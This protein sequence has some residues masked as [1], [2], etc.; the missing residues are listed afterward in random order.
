L[1]KARSRMV[2][3]SV[4]LATACDS[5]TAPPAAICHIS[6]VVPL[7]LQV[8][9]YRAI[10]PMPSE[11]C[12]LFPANASP[13]TAEYLLV[14]QAT[15][16]T[17]DLTST[18]KLTGGT[19]AM[20]AP[21]VVAALQSAPL[22]PPQR[23]H[24]MLREMERT[25]AYPGVTAAAAARPQL[26]APPAAIPPPNVGD[27]G[28]FKV[29][30]SITNLRYDSV[31]AF[32]Q[33]VGAHIAIYVD[34][35][36]PPGLTISGLDSLRDAFDQKLY[37]ADT[38]AFG[39]ESDIDGNGIVIVLMT[40][41]VNKMVTAAECQST[42]YVAGFFYGADI[43]LAVN[44]SFNHGEIFY[45]IVADPGA[46]L[47]CGHSVNA[48]KQVVAGTLVHEF[49]HMISYNQH[50]RIRHT[51][52]EVLWLNE[53]LSH[54]A[55]ELGGRTFLPDMTTFCYYV[56][57]DLYNAGQYL[58]APGTYPLVDTAGIGGLANRGAGWLFVRY[59]VDRFGQDTTLAGNN[60]IT[61]ALDNTSA[62]GTIN[63]AQ[64]TGVPFATT[65]QEWALANWV[66]DLPGF[67][68]PTALKYE[69]WA[70]RSA[71]PTLRATCGSP[72]PPTFPLVA[73]A[74]AGPNINLSGTMASG[75]GAVYQRALQGPGAPAFTLLFSDATGAQLK[76]TV[77][78]RLNVIRIR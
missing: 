48:V 23:F 15:T 10:D 60:A 44:L 65:A 20:A 6:A 26:V 2:F 61:R 74:D 17:P 32:A 67:T 40:N 21:S 46:A 77:L 9:Q 78:P 14:P 39:R 28:R 24:Q 43:D 25:G 52:A 54:Y 70:F 35:A 7:S 49:Q 16:E 38:A 31:T 19:P 68:A 8:G 36:A 72:V 50:V 41:V 33:S 76:S 3:W 53:A 63:V 29:L 13:D 1:V 55:E 51:P 4:V 30:S 71:F 64:V 57:G 18:F 58:T 56:S 45:T 75:S 42:G 22:S 73:T 59:L 34:S 5:V 12:V 11:G 69:K 47:S 66:S 37:P 62:T 27:R